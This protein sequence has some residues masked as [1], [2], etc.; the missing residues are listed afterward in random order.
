MSD[1]YLEREIQ[2]NASET[3][4]RRPAIIDGALGLLLSLEAE[5]P[6]PV[7][8]APPKSDVD[9]F[10]QLRLE[11]RAKNN[12]EIDSANRRADA[13]ADINRLAA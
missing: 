7:E 2:H 5:I 3:V 10:T 8:V 4:R 1:E 6:P 12:E 13:R 11:K 9:A